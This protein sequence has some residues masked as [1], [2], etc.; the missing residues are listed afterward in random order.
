MLALAAG[1]A[2]LLFE[3]AGPGCVRGRCPEGKM[4]CGDPEG[5]RRE[6][7]ALKEESR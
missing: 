6:F 5:V 1:K 7:A 4:T 3:A 2:P